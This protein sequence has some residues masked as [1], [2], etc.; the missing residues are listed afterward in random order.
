MIP[1]PIP[2]N[3][4]ARLNKLTT[5]NILDTNAENIFDEVTKTAAAICDAE[6]SLV[7]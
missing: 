7:S 6:I 4:T 2:Q 5:Y 1:A 3:E